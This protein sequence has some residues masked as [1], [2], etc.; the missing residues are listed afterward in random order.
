MSFSPMSPYMPSYGNSSLL[1]PSTSMTPMS[2]M[3]SPYAPAFPS[4]G[5]GG[6]STLGGTGLSGDMQSALLQ[7]VQMMMMLIMQ[8]IQ[9]LLGGGMG[10]MSGGGSNGQ[11]SGDYSQ[12]LSAG[13]H[14]GGGHWFGGPG[15]YNPGGDN[16]GQG[17]G[18]SS[19][20]SNP[21]D[22]S[23]SPSNTGGGAE[24]SGSSAGWNN[25]V[26]VFAS[27]KANEETWGGEFLDG[28]ENGMDNGKTL[29]QADQGLHL[30]RQTPISNDA[31]VNSLVKG[32]GGKALIVTGDNYPTE[33]DAT[34]LAD[35]LKKQGMDVQ[36]IHDASPKQ[37]KAA[38]QQMGGQNG[39]QCLVAVLA[40][41]A[42]DD[43]GKNNGTIALG[44]GDGDQWLHESDLKSWV[45]QYLSPSY[46][47]VNVVFNSCFSGNFVQ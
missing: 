2:Q 20:S 19:G 7:I 23:N 40:H 36:I 31:K 24:N 13:G 21:P 32:K 9:G 8:L 41:G 34:K 45:N 30:S 12:S 22:N 38:I 10:D 29:T 39:Q 37:L 42:K 47:N 3:T 14:G 16:S 11:Q 25:N 26:S 1:N 17:T 18:D 15:S 35:N 44:K 33:G 4:T 28:L 5:F 6:G 46:G 43:S 27:S